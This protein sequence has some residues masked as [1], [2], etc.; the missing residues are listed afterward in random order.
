LAQV[1]LPLK[2]SQLLGT[3]TARKRDI[4]GNPIGVANKNPILD[5]RI[6]EVIFPDGHSAEFAANTIAECIYSQVDSK[7][8]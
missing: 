7:G 5:T 8:N 1:I 2:D 6:Y 3:V 4:H